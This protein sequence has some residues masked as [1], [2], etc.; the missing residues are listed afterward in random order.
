MQWGKGY[1]R[2]EETVDEELEF[3]VFKKSIKKGFSC[4]H[5][6]YLK[7]RNDFKNRKYKYSTKYF[8][9]IFV[10]LCLNKGQE[11][12]QHQNRSKKATWYISSHMQELISLKITPKVCNLDT[13]YHTSM[14]SIQLVQ[15]SI[16]QYTLRIE[17][18]LKLFFS[19]FI[20]L[21][22]HT[23]QYTAIWVDMHHTMPWYRGVWGL[24]WI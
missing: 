18:A 8:F 15:V 2:I 17:I 9:S 3:L 23:D 6:F 16:V 20:L 22:P 24:Y 19:L 7:I 12:K 1:Q 4:F 13:K 11:R 5:F 21:H 14:L 10:F